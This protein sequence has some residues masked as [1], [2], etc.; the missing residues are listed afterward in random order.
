METT[1]SLCINYIQHLIYRM[2][3]NYHLFYNQDELLWGAS[4][5][6]TATQN[7]SYMNFIQNN[8]HILGADEDDFFFS[9]D[10]KKVGTK[11]LLSKVLKQI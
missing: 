7:S 5:L 10:D 8:G 9:W 1:S 4:W 2:A 3:L 6:H 11:I